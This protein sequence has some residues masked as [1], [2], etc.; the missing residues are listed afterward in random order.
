MR[1]V[2]L[3][4]LN[5]IFEGKATGETFNGEG[6]TDILI[7]VGDRNIFIAECFVWEG[8]EKAKRKL[9]DQLFKYAMWRD[10]KTALVVFS[11][12][13]NM[14]A[15]VRAVKEMV[16]THPQCIKELNYPSE[17]GARYLF[18]RKDDPDRHF[19]LTCLVFDVPKPD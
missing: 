19:Y 9:D 17:T 12:R 1:F 10:T 14:T 7:R 16:K 2:L 5:A 8:E 6:K 18:R 15:V 3:L 4:G 13:M 11:R